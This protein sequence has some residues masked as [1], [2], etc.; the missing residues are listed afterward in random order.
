MT[1]AVTG[2]DSMKTSLIVVIWILIA[3]QSTVIAQ[4][5]IGDAGIRKSAYKLTEESPSVYINFDKIESIRTKASS[6]LYDVV[7]FR[8]HNNTKFVLRFCTYDNSMSRTGKPGIHYDIEQMWSSSADGSSTPPV[9]V[10]SFPATDLCNYQNLES[11]KAYSFGVPKTEL[12]IDNSRLRIR[13]QFPWESERDVLL[14]NEVE[15]FAY[16]YPS[17]IR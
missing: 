10:S 1:E 9:L 3:V 8:L 14:G 4:K 12:L 7:W 5:R 2:E 17:N 16:F 6:T 13:F 11:G 15:H